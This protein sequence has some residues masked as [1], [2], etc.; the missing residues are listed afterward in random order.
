MPTIEVEGFYFDERNAVK[1]ASHDV[2]VREAYQVLWSK[3]RAFRNH[4]RGAP[5]IIIGPTASGR[6]ITLPIDPTDEPGIWK[7]RTA[8]DSSRKE[9]RRYARE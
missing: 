2:T 7:P 8:Y 4:S 1:L 5:W 6:M 9:R 3:P